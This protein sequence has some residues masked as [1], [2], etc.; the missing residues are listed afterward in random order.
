MKKNSHPKIRDTFCELIL[1]DDYSKAVEYHFYQKVI[2][3]ILGC[4]WMEVENWGSK[5]QSITTVSCCIRKVELCLKSQIQVSR[6]VSD[7][8]SM[9]SSE[10]T[11]QHLSCVVL[12]YLNSISGVVKGGSHALSGH[13]SHTYGKLINRYKHRYKFKIKIK[14][15]L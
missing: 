2:E 12:H 7:G 5:R 9:Y 3:R 14:Y 15:F 8:K 4:K 1:K 11:C 13:Y 10:F 6:E